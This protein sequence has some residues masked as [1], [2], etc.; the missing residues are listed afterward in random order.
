VINATIYTLRYIVLPWMVKG[1][2]PQEII[3][4]YTADEDKYQINHPLIQNIVN[5]ITANTDHLLIKSIKLYNYIKNHLEYILD[6][7]WDDAPT[8]LLRGNGSCSEYCFAY[9]ALLRAA[10]IPARY[11]GGTVLKTDD[12]PYVDSVFHRIVEIYLPYYGWIP[13]DPTW[14]DYMKIPLFYF[15]SHQNNF[16]ILNIG[17]GP[18]EYL[19]W[20]Y[21]HWEEWIPETDNVTVELSFTWENWKR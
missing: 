5:D 16:L 19:D 10:G 2:I 18:S 21:C 8:V 1:E 17:G 12:M 6:D 11:V 14:G 4:N 3:E 13:V 15:G 7:R 20:N 9:I